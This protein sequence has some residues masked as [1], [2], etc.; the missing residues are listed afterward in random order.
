MSG[1]EKAA[2]VH[3]MVSPKVPVAGPSSIGMVVRQA[4]GGSVQHR[5]HPGLCPKTGASG[6]TW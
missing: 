4:A 6:C 5:N 3:A 2:E 1:E